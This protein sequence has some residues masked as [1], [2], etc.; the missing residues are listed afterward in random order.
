[1]TGGAKGRRSQVLISSP[2]DI[3]VMLPPRFAAKISIDKATGCWN[4]TASTHSP[5][6]Y[7]NKKYGQFKLPRVNGRQV[8]INTHR[9]MYETAYGP[10]LPGLR[11]DV[12]HI[13]RNTLCVNP[14]HLRAITHCDNL[15]LRADRKGEL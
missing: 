15:M 6:R 5:A 3:M 9:F 12:D 14:R 4:W 11:L 2:T 8:A 1:M 10:L 7:P 13:C